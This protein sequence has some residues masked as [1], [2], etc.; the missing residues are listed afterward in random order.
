VSVRTEGDPAALVIAR[1]PRKDVVA[2]V[3]L[4]DGRFGLAEG[5]F[6]SYERTVTVHDESAGT[7]TQTMRY[8]L[9]I[10]WFGPLYAL[11][12]RSILKS[13]PRPGQALP[14]WSPPDRMNE[15]TSSILGVLAAVSVIAG[16][17]N[18]LFTQTVAFASDEFGTGTG[19]QGVALAVVRVGVVV[20]L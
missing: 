16:F 11:P 14:W 19:A 6:R 18:T 15:R 9:A 2:E 12:T 5:P 20:A 7:F 13:R 10:P 8:R 3:E 17:V 4:G 1:T